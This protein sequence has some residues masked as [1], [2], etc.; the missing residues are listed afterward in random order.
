MSSVTTNIDHNE[1]G[2]AILSPSSSER[3]IN[4]PPSALLADS[5]P[6]TVS[7]YA[8][9][10]TTA[11]E[12]AEYVLTAWKKGEWEPYV[13]EIPVPDT[14][15]L[16]SFFNE[17]MRIAV[18]NYATFVVNEF[19]DMA[20]GGNAYLTLEQKLDISK[21]AP[22]SFGSADATITNERII[23]IT[24][25]K[26]GKGVKVPA[27]SSQFKMYALGAFEKFGKPYTKII[28]MSVVQPRLNH[29]ETLEITVTEL[30]QWA[31]GVLR[32]AANLAIKGLG[33]QKTGTWCQFCPVK[34]T[35][36]AQYNE[37]LADFEAAP[38]ALLMTEDDIVNLLGKIDRYKSWLESV[39]Q[40]AYSEAIA[41]RK[42]NGY[43][44]IEGRSARKIVEPD[45]VRNDLLETYMED[46]V[47]KIDLKG[48][49][50]L[51]KLV[52]KKLFAAKYGK[53]IQTQPGQ[54]KLV[55]DSHPG[56]EYSSS[57]DFDIEG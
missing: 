43:K 33:E 19:Y 12:L 14:I 22:E 28:R 17:E 2:H 27:T 44:L 35:C 15:A 47:L 48:I 3:W 49:T 52:G 8:A 4:C 16:S 25:L 32:P 6:E 24:D 45:K 11:H 41:G 26:Y 30:L 9:E 51:E 50:D 1:R 54:P 40:Y 10:G 55:P 34:A 39:N 5:I 56:K 13:D 53:Y 42:W 31:E 37:L 21:Y 18:E 23:H 36:K 7:S 46:E 57:S 29:Y 38:D 20:K